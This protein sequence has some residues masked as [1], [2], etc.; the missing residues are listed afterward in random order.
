MWQQINKYQSKLVQ[1][2]LADPSLL[3]LSALDA[4]IS[5]AGPA[6][7]EDLHRELYRR[8]NIM[9]LILAR[10]ANGILDALLRTESVPGRIF[11]RDCETRTFLHDIPVVSPEGTFE[12]LVD[13]LTL[14]LKE[15]KGA[16]IAGLGVIA[17]GSVTLEQAFVTYSSIL[18]AAFVKYHLDFAR[19][20]EIYA[21]NGGVA[22]H[23]SEPI[24]ASI[25]TYLEI[26][27]ALQAARRPAVGPLG[28]FP[29]SGRSAVED[30]IAECGRCT[31]EAGL[32]DSYFGNVSYNDGKTMWISQTASS[33]D[34][35]IGFIDEVP[36]DGSS[37]VGITASSEFPAHMGTARLTNRQAILHGH[38]KYSVIMSMLCREEGCRETECDTRCACD[39]SVS[40]IP[41]V[42]GEIGAG[43]L[44]RSVP[45]ALSNAPAVIVYGHGV[46]SV[47]ENDFRDAFAALAS[48][49]E[50]CALLYLQEQAALIEQIRRR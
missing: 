25:S 45:R 30:A 48:T 12:D 4:E 19:R 35:L 46:F 47:G 18:H 3:S 49:E 10:P 2:G 5:Y 14:V 26:Q 41:I 32:V 17:H 31:V 43:G 6:D 9:G 21:A 22:N 40:G 42:I 11:P 38:P 1:R 23:R 39:R 34:D 44:A 20:L 33:L 27:Q 7:L 8:L 13:R 37:S 36:M 24:E 16:V 15:R 50:K 28:S 29:F